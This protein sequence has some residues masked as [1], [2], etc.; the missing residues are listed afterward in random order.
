MVASPTT[1]ES[2]LPVWI[3]EGNFR[4]FESHGFTCF[5][6]RTNEMKNLCGYV[7]LSPSHALH[8]VTYQDVAGIPA[9]CEW[10][11][12]SFFEEASLLEV[13]FTEYDTKGVD[14]PANNDWV[15]GFDCAHVGADFV[16][17]FQNYISDFTG[18]RTVYRDM[19][20]VESKAPRCHRE[21]SK[22][23][24]FE[25]LLIV[26]SATTAVQVGLV[27]SVAWLGLACLDPTSLLVQ[28][29]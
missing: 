14:M 29:L 18:L 22:R 16:P 11:F 21:A 26:E 13:L 19:T 7:A 5:I 4:A 9:H 28:V 15:L 2:P 23:R 1:T 10:T 20:Y 12:S 25:P 27:E 6:I 24:C 8:G 17:A 3:T